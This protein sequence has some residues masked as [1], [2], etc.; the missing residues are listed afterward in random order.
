MIDRFD[1]IIEVPEVTPATLFSPAASE[2]TAVIARRV[3]AARAY[4]GLRPQQAVIVPMRGCTLI[5]WQR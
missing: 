1:L 5:S 2:T 4:V 3:E